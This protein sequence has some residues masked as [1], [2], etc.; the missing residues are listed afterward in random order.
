MEEV[1][2]PA[3][4]F[5][6]GRMLTETTARLGPA[7]ILAV[8]EGRVRLSTEDGQ[9]WGTLALAFPYKPVAGD[10]VLAIGQ[11]KAWYVIGVLKGRGVSSFVAPAD[12]EFRAPNG[13]IG[14]IAAEGVR[15]QAPDVEVEADRLELAARTVFERFVRAYR[16]VAE[17]FHLRAGSVKTTVEETWDVRAGRITERADGDVRIDGEKIH[18]G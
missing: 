9:A 13:S 6:G 4:G 11:D 14:L 7:T 15:I 3:P 12:L 8:E 1:A 5:A 10:T 2:N 18:L 17:A 16:R